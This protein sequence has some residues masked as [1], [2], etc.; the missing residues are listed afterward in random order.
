MALTK[1][2]T[3][4]KPVIDKR[5][6]ATVGLRLQVWDD[7]VS[8]IDTTVTETCP[9]DKPEQAE[10]ELKNKAQALINTYL[11]E[12]KLNVDTK[13]TTAISNVDSALSLEET[14]KEVF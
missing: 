7:D 2:V 8:V 3:R 11:E 14:E 5:N 4:T 13:Y 10:A 12:K 9:K 1:T 6:I